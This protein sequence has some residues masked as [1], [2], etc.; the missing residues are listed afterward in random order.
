[1]TFDES[2]DIRLARIIKAPRSVVWTAWA[3]PEHFARWWTPAPVVTI[4][5]KFDLRPGGAFDTTI[6]LEDGT[7]FGG[8]GCF[9]DVVAR[10]RIVFTDALRE[11]W[12]PNKETFFSA[13][14]TMED[15]PDGTLYTAVA[16]HNDEADRKKHVDMG[17]E[18]GWGTAIEQLARLAQ[19]LAA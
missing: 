1:M 18:T 15:H 4:V 6:K 16:L 17:F 14:I 9:L 11:D 5:D 7:E 19:E 8:Q 10:E 2:L 12:R 13:I 3:E